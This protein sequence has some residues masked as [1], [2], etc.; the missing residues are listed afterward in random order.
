M[1]SK[2]RK[3]EQPVSKVVVDWSDDHPVAGSIRRG[4]KW[5]FA[6]LMQMCTPYWRLAKR[7]GIA[8]AR[9][10]EINGGSV[11]TRAE[12]EALAKAWWITPEGL[13]ASM[14]DDRAVL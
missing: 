3:G 14:P 11:I 10:R 1:M 12:L 6:W 13:Q 8:E 7:T 9:L 5:F 2:R 4:D